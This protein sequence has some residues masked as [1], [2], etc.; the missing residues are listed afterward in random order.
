MK[1]WW[2][3]KLKLG[4]KNYV[5]YHNCINRSHAEFHIVTK[6]GQRISGKGVYENTGIS[7]L[8]L[9]TVNFTLRSGESYSRHIMAVEPEHAKCLV[10]AEHPKGRLSEIKVYHGQVHVK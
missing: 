8:K 2:R 10:Y 7:H 6:Y 5:E 3:V 9:Y 1:T 4:N